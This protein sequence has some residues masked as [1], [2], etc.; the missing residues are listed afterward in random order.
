[1]KKPRGARKGQL[2]KLAIFTG[3]FSLGIFLAQYLLPVDWQLPAGV[4]ALMLACSRLL[5]RNDRGRRLLLTGVGLALAFGW[6]WLVIRQVQMP[7]EAL[8]ETEQ[9]VTMTLCDYADKTDYGAKAVVRVEGL[10]GKAVYYGD[11]ALLSVAPGQTVTDRVYW[12]SAARIR[13]ED[14]TSF[15]SKG[16]FLRAYPRG[17]AV[18]GSGS[19]GAVRWWPARTGQAMREKIAAVFSGDTAAFL[20]AVLTGD[21]SGLSADRAADLSEAGLYHILAV[22]GM[23]CGFLL[24]LVVLLLGRHRRR[25]VAGTMLVLLVFY[26]LLTGGSPSVVRACVM[27]TMLLAAPLFGRESDGPT[28]LL[29]ALFLILLHNPFAAASVSLQLSFA[30]MAGILYLTPRLSRLL[31]GTGK[32]GRLF[33]FTVAG[34]SATMGALVFTVPLSAYYF[35]TL[36]LISPLSNLLCLWAASGVFL[37]GLA[38]VAAGFLWLPLG[39]LLGVLPRLLTG[40]ILGMAHLLARLPYHAVYFDNPYLPYWLAFVYLLFWAAFLVKRSPRRKYAAAALCGLVTLAAAVHL[41]TAR[42]D[43]RL[44]IVM[45]DV[46]QGQCVLLASGKDCAVVDCGGSGWQDAGEL[47]ARRLRTMGYTRLDHLILSHY[48]KD[49]ISGFAGLLARM[50]A[51]E[52][53]V[54]EGADDREVR[55]AV[56]ET[57]AGH[58][59]AVRSVTGETDLKLGEARLR[60]LPSGDDRNDNARSLAVLV[61][62]EGQ[63]L[64]LTGDMDRKAE[65]RLLADWA[66]PDLEYLAAGHHGSGASTSVRLLD[67]LRPETVCI[68]VGA[69]NRYGHP[70]KE[71]LRR[72]AERGCAV[73]RTDLHGDIQISWN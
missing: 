43:G 69:D 19:A 68:S 65:E 44:E 18:F 7:M 32:R 12:K 45:L 20:T 39:M 29:T 4:A 47:V 64:L 66:L 38:A 37:L 41:G 53:L 17:E 56:W 22:S 72:L 27:L 42:Y 54:T 40:Y 6:N 60:I 1:M 13:D 15:T 24:T 48:D 35:G 57:A 73:Y 46:G 55:S 25:L 21:R 2:R 8:A 63:D 34:F 3:A 49:H 59:A 52:V 70:A 26:A 9:T 58:G 23:H 67:A 71:T 62:L 31:K 36:V 33:H 51:G 28:S 10:P 61:S 16:I 5:L 14:V 50:D 11:A 30:A